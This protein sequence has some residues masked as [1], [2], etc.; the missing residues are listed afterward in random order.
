M[1]SDEKF[2]E[3]ATNLARQGSGKVSPNPMVGAVVVKNG[4]IIGQGYHEQ[5]GETHAEVNAIEDSY[6]QVIEST[7]YITLEPC[8]HYGNT[9]PC[10]ERIVRE[11]IKRVVVG[12]IDPDPRMRGKSVA[13]LRTS[14]IDV[15]T[16]TLKHQTDELIKFY[17]YWKQTKCPYVTV[18]LA[19]TRD[20]FI[21]QSDGTSKWISCQ[22]SREEV[23]QM[24]G[25]F[26]AV[27]VGTNTV[28]ADDPALTV[29]H[30]PGRNPN[31]VIIDRLAKISHQA[32]VFENNTNRI[33]YFST[34]KRNDLS[35]WV[36]EIQLSKSK[37]SLET[38]LAILGERNQISLLIEGGGQLASSFLSQSLCNEAIIYRSQETFGQG[39]PFTDSL[40]NNNQYEIFHRAQSGADEKII[41]R[42]K[43]V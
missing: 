6:G 33:F 15:K 13:Y 31:R 27:L 37:F 17:A 19:V 21:A 4:N 39:I 36:T 1:T 2:M 7:M 32:K 41:F 18:K 29:R 3:L 26:D 12:S 24:R 38:M 14:G 20:G 22:T 25:D 9:P 34:V 8:N 28:L 10:L 30:V 42:R 16:G 43:H 35:N 23:H 5:Y 40:M 11:Q